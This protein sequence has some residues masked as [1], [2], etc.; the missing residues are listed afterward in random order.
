MIYVWSMNESYALGF[1]GLW[2][3]RASIL[4]TRINLF[5]PSVAATAL[6]PHRLK[7]VQSKL[8]GWEATSHR[9]INSGTS[10]WPET[11][12]FYYFVSIRYMQVDLNGDLF[13]L[14]GLTWRT[15]MPRMKDELKFLFSLKYLPSLSLFPPLSIPIQAWGFGLTRDWLFLLFC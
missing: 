7:C 1:P 11:G 8:G 14:S 5:C 4:S 3:A 6:L 2:S 13:C 12:Y 9:H 10:V 15:R